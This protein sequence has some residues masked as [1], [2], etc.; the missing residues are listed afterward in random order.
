MAL[1]QISLTWSTECVTIRTVA[2]LSRNSLIRS[3]HFS[4]KEVFGGLELDGHNVMETDRYF[5]IDNWEDY[6]AYMG[7]DYAKYVVKPKMILK[8]HEHN[9]FGQDNIKDI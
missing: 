6:A 7:S 5:S 8:Y 9:P 1:W 3:K 2:P 4:L